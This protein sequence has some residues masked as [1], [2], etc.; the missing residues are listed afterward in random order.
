MDSA[1]TTHGDEPNAPSFHVDRGKQFISEKLWDICHNLGATLS[2]ERTGACFD[3]AI[4]DAR[5]STLK[6]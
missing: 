4:A 3:N 6:T 5:W 1:Q 2:V